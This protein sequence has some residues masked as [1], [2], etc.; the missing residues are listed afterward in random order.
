MTGSAARGTLVAMRAYGVLGLIVLLC[1][2]AGDDDATGSG[3]GSGGSGATAG[4]G[5]TA[6]TG[7]AAD[8]GPGG[9]DAGGDAGL[10]PPPDYATE[11]AWLCLPGT[12]ADVCDHDLD[13]HVVAADGTTE[14]EAHVRNPSPL[15]DCFYV[16]PTVS[17]DATL[18]SDLLPADGEEIMVV[19]QQAARLGSVCAVYAP[20]YRQVTLQAIFNPSPDIAGAREIA[21]GDVLAA[22]DHYVSQRNGGRGFVLIGHSQG[23]GVLNRL[24]RER[25]D[26]SA[27]R[28]QLVAA[29]LIG[30]AV[31]VPDGADV[32]GDFD[33]VP[34]CR[35]LDQTGCVVSYASFASTAPPPENSRFGAPRAGTTGVALCVN[36]ASPGGGQAALTPYFATQ[37]AFDL[38]ALSLTEPYVTFPGLFLGECVRR[39]GF[40]ILEVTVQADVADPRP[41]AIDGRLGADWGLH[42]WDVHLA[43]GDIERMV[44]AQAAAYLAN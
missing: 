31:T 19:R 29:Y 27:L 22:F 11:Q 5:G 15:I 13:A 35:A 32:G 24:V 18:N 28:S 25:I 1:G 8:A 12:A 38:S 41:D 33:N 30:S 6:A 10:A 3:S 44:A 9:F 17:T 39:N 4:S 40:D 37:G 7:G 20:L 36:P 23:G 21:Y 14:V 42:L 43:M 16:Y 26:D 34:A 2:C